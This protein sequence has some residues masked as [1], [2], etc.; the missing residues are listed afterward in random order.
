MIGSGKRKRTAPAATSRV[1]SPY[2]ALARSNQLPE[3]FVVAVSSEL[4]LAR[5][6]K[7][8]ESF[9]VAVSSEL[10]LARFK[11]LL[12]SSV[13]ESVDPPLTRSNRPPESS[14]VS[15]VVSLRRMTDYSF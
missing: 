13:D 12:E 10:P 2:F 8:L 9:V 11:K 3:L 14:S 5:F 4:P 15:S 7:L 1:P 6:K